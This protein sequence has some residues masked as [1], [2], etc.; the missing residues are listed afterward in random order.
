MRRRAKETATLGRMRQPEPI[1]LFSVSS[2]EFS[3]AAKDVQEIRSTDNF[4]GSSNEMHCPG[5]PKV[6]QTI[7]R[8]RHTY[9]VVNAARHFGLPLSRPTLVLI[10]QPLRA[11]VLI[12]R[13][14][15]MTEISAIYPLPK[16]FVG[17]EQHWYRG[18]A[19]LDDHVIPVIR[20][21]GFLTAE[22]LRQLE[23]VMV[24][25]SRQELEEATR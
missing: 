6:Q 15:G 11:A 10:L 25:K 9:Y 3:I 4:S 17:E 19:Y 24:G 16:V 22:D 8:A 1:I 7:E 21:E 18:L 14:E 2:Q 5:V 12:D 23:E 20:P 13:I